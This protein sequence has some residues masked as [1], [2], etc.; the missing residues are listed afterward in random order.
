MDS[1]RNFL[2]GYRLAIIIGLLAL[3][4]VFLGT[5]SLG[6]VFG[7]S[8]G[9]V[10]G[11]DISELDFSVAA[12]MRANKLKET[13]PKI[14]KEVRGKGLLLGLC[15]YEDQTNFIN[16]LLDNKLLTVK[17]AENVVRLLPPLNVTKK[18]INLSLK[19]IDRVCKNY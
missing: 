8:Y 1:L 11:E 18:E 5:S 9:S 16:K 19:I 17:A 14:I 4:F 12:N 6:T 3:P 7:G 2:T 13:Y 15:L 10:N